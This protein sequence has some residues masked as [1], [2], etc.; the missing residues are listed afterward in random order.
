MEHL[1]KQQLILVALLVS[2]MTSIATGVVTVS[3]MEQVPDPVAQTINRIVERTIETVVQAPETPQAAAVVTT[4][5]TIVVKED[6]R[7]MEAVEKNS[8]HI[9]RIKAS[10]AENARNIALGFLVGGEGLVV[11]SAEAL[12]DIMQSHV[13]FDPNYNYKASR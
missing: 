3:L 11:T 6:D 10:E 2:F 12:R 8:P 9:V 5:E 7:V 4:K 13:N 1:T